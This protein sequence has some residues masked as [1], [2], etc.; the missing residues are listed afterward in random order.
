[1]TQSVCRLE[2]TFA[3]MKFESEKFKSGKISIVNI[4]NPSP[5]LII[6]LVSLKFRLFFAKDMTL[7][8]K[9]INIFKEF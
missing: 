8:F 7:L 2:V 4:D 9:T 1:M 3:R 6:T 5:T